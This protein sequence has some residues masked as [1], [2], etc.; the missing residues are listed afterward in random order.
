MSEITLEALVL[1]R[2]DEARHTLVIAGVYTHPEEAEAHQAQLPESSSPVIIPMTMAAALA[3]L[4]E[5]GKGEFEHIFEQRLTR[6]AE[7]VGQLTA[8]V[9]AQHAA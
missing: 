7:R 9:T 4:R 8:V 2:L 3:A 6:L 5:E 1:Y